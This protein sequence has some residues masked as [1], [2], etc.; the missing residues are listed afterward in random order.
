MHTYTHNYNK[1]KHREEAGW[2]RTKNPS[3]LDSV[4][5]QD[6]VYKYRVSRC[7][8]TASASE[9]RPSAFSICILPASSYFHLLCQ[10]VSLH[11]SLSWN[12][13]NLQASMSTI[14][15]LKSAYRSR[16]QH[17]RGRHKI[18]FKVSPFLRQRHAGYFDFLLP[19][20]LETGNRLLQRMGY[21]AGNLS[22]SD[23]S[24]CSFCG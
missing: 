19:Q 16:E 20:Y 14:E 8:Q 15:I 11:Y 5:E 17:K 22:P 12:T 18:L 9:P 21:S 4:Q 23:C 6:R 3:S 13:E 2:S 1:N 10:L 24:V 7:S